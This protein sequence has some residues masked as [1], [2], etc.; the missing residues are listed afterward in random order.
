MTAIQITTPATPITADVIAQFVQWIDRG[1]KTTRSYLNNLK[2]FFA[3]LRF[4]GVTAPQREDIISYR[5]WLAG[6]HKAI[7]LDTTAAQG[8]TYRT[9]SNGTPIKVTCKPST[10]AAYLRSVFQFFRWTQ[11]QGLYPDISANVHA[12]KVT[13]NTHA[14]DALTASEVRTIE[15]SITATAEKKAQTA[16]S[17][18]KD[19]A[20]RI[21]R[22]TEQGKRDQAMFLLSV[23][24][25][26]R[27]CE[28]SRAC[29]RDL[30]TK[31][32]QSFLWIWGKGHTAPDT[33]KPIPQEVTEAI[34][35]YL[36]SR[37][38]PYTGASPLFAAT[39][40]R[41]AGGRIATTT[42]STM[43]KHAM[44]TAGYDSERLTAHSLRHT[45]AQTALQ[46]SGRNIYT[47]QGFLR[48][49]SPST[50]ET[51]LRETAETMQAERSLAQGIYDT[52][53]GKQDNRGIRE[54]LDM[55]LTSLDPAKLEKLTEI[56]EAF[57]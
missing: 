11:A 49:A 40:N 44:Q 18:A 29:V 46:V 15:T 5:H 3:Y 12:P 35:D 34:N 4:T 32:G 19:T 25:G 2:Q 36:A 21:Q 42:I 47:V 22:A 26:L 17:A 1:E 9:D 7:A 30:E 52:Y 13:G 51:Y 43:L 54:K 39:G 33:R 56:A 50:T 10:Q 6:E 23:S 48:H 45:A 20:G 8:W 41:N 14:K 55:L 28:L 38:D 31:G 27:C 24:C 57:A 37:K 16:A 53:H